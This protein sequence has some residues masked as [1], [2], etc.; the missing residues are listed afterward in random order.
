MGQ[1]G[2]KVKIKDLKV[3]DIFTFPCFDKAY[4]VYLGEGYY[5]DRAFKKPLE[6][7][8][9]IMEEVFIIGRQVQVI[10]EE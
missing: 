8:G 7:G 4:C 1:N 10:F 3:W 6:I 2:K 9:S 5:F